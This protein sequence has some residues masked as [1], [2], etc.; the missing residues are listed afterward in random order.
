MS[1]DAM[2][3]GLPMPEPVDVLAVNEAVLGQSNIVVLGPQDRLVIAFKGDP[4]AVELLEM[5]DRIEERWPAAADRIL[6]IAGAEQLAVL[7]GWDRAAADAAAA[8]AG[9]P[10]RPPTSESG[11]SASPD[12]RR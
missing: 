4:T 12:G 1:E 7:R 8:R 11:V 10:V 6:L 3:A 5:R 2:A 9:K